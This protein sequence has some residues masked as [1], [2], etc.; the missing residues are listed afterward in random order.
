MLEVFRGTPNFRHF[1]YPKRARRK[2]SK[3]QAPK[4]KSQII[5]KHQGSNFQNHVVHWVLVIGISNL[6]FQFLEPENVDLKIWKKDKNNKNCFV[7]NLR[8]KA[9]RKMRDF[10]NNLIIL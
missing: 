1:K 7:P 6:G 5:S 8:T 4:T 2:N 9:G 10:L 3:T